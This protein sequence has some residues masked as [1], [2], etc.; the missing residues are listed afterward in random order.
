MSATLSHSPRY[1]A[2][3]RQSSFYT[4]LRDQLLDSLVRAGQPGDRVPSERQL[5]KQFDTSAMTISRILQEFQENGLLQRVPG[6]GTFICESPISRGSET[7][8]V[9]AGINGG[10]EVPVDA[11]YWGSVIPRLGTTAFQSPAIPVQG[12]ALPLRH[13]CIITHISPDPEAMA[14]EYWTH[15]LVST[16]ERQLQRYGTKTT[17][18]NRKQLEARDPTS[19]MD[20]LLSEGVDSFLYQG[21][22]GQWSD[23]PQPGFDWN[24]EMLRLRAK[25]TS[26]LTITQIDLS[27][28]SRSPF[29]SVSFDNVRGA[30]LATRHLLDMGHRDICF[31]TRSLDYPW[32]QERIEGFWQALELA[33]VPTEEEAFRQEVGG[34][35]VCCSAKPPAGVEEWPWAA[36]DVVRH[37]FEDGDAYRRYTAVVAINDEVALAFIDEAGKRGFRVPEDFSIVGF[38]DRLESKA[39]GLTTI[40][41]PIEEIG[42]AA[43][44][45][46]MQ[47]HNEPFESGKINMVLNPSLVARSTTAQILRQTN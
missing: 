6:K 27:G 19:V 12:T 26:A 4:Q 14:R 17:L 2:Q 40:H 22:G 10:V 16:V 42:E 45:L 34:G 29:D 20:R 47:R 7:G 8:E 33:G 43:V 23:A 5:A 25:S 11:G 46:M 24:R 30:F 18:I 44:S 15:R 13:T 41:L 36:Y 3:A 28:R 9:A 31:L 21:E 32:I 1:P 35:R 39:V 38:D 37:F